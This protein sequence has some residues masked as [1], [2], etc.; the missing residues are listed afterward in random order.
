[1]R[2]VTLAAIQFSCT[3]DRDENVATAERLVRRAAG[4]G[5]NVILIPELFETPYFC[6]VQNQRFLELARPLQDHPTIEHFRRVAAELGVVIPVSVF[7]RAG[8]ALFNSAVVIDADGATVGHYRKSHIPQAPGYEEK[9]YFSPGDTGF[10]PIDTAYGKLG[11]AVC[12]DQWFPE[13]ARSLVLQGAEFLMYPT[14]IGNEPKHADL[15]SMEHWR[16]VM[17]GHAAANMVPVVAANR[18]GSESVEGVP[19]TFYGSS[20]ITNHLGA[21]AA[22]ADRNSEAVLASRFDLDECRAYRES[23]GCFRDRR[24]DLYGALATLDGRNVGGVRI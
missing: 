6:A 13:A 20:F 16:V 19:M 22:A 14:A 10:K 21:L 18:I 12:W 15:D 1:M 4:E 2:T 24:P 3:W 8:P 11:I 17:R 23:W 5:A 7:E 9:Y